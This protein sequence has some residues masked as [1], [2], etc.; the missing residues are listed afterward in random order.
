MKT[1]IESIYKPANVA[2]AL[3]TCRR[4]ICQRV[5]EHSFLLCG[6]YSSSSVSFSSSS[7]L[8]LTSSRSCS[9]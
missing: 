7:I 9:S 8:S 6:D 5:D 1:K 3:K 2:R 4:I